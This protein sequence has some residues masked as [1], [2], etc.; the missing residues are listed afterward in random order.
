VH[1]PPISLFLSDLPIFPNISFPLRFVYFLL[2]TLEQVQI[3][4][5]SL[6]PISKYLITF[7]SDTN[8][9][10]VYSARPRS[11]VRDINEWNLTLLSPDLWVEG[12]FNYH[13]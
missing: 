8:C 9:Q 1:F 10:G 12:T 5:K 11:S 6:L 3:D 13:V 2:I 4:S 7:G